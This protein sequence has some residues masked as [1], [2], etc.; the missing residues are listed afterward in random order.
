MRTLLLGVAALLAAGLFPMATVWASRA[1]RRRP[2]Y[3]ALPWTQKEARRKA[4]LAA[5]NHTSRGR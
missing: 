5:L 2:P 4:A 1:F 3:A